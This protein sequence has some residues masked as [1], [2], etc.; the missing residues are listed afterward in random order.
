MKKILFIASVEINSISG[1]GKVNYAL[2]RALVDQYPDRVDV[3][4]PDVRDKTK[5]A[6]FYYIPYLSGWQKVVHLLKGKIHRYT[7]CVLNFV[8]HHSGEYSHCLINCGLFGDL[9]EPLKQRGLKVCLIHHNFEAKYQM[10]NKRPS[11]FGGMT[12]AFV[13]RNES[14]G[15]RTSDMNL[16]LTKDDAER[17][18]SAYGPTQAHNHVIGLFEGSNEPVDIPQ[19][20]LCANR[21]V[22]T[23]GLGSVQSVDGI[24]QF[25]DG[26]DRLL[27]N[28]FLNDYEVLIA[29]SNPSQEILKIG[30]ENSHVKIVANPCDMLSTIKMGGIYICPVVKGSGIKTR[31]L[32]GLKLGM[33]I[34]AHK[35]SAQG[36]EKLYRN[37]WFQVYEDEES[38]LNGLKTI[39][40]NLFSVPK[41]R[42]A[43]IE[44]YQGLFSLNV[45]KKNFEM[46]MDEFVNG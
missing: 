32:D 30:K 11:T 42:H 26:Y 28:F 34:L 9:V 24:K 3:L 20:P 5:D 6:H 46:C 35:V 13:R 41:L 25:F 37:S 12:D 27:S 23:G 10:D 44:E 43:I 17:L 39:A 33:P 19:S 1:G 15:Y 7:S 36:Y 38:F 22:I 4:Q 2:W 45:G 8:D 29:G 31:I 14:M 40:D 16:F 21:L 18:S